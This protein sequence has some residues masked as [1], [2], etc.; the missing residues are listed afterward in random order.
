VLQNLPEDAPHQ[1]Y[2][3]TSDWPVT[4]GWFCFG[5]YSIY[6]KRPGNGLPQEE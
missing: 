5:L 6:A 3:R 2:R 1:T 4:I